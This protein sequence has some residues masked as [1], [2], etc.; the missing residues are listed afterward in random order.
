MPCPS[1][2][3]KIFCASP[4]RLSLSKNLIAFSAFSKT[5]LLNVNHLLVCHKMFWSS[6]KKI[7]NSPNYFGTCRRTRHKTEYNIHNFMI[8]L[9]PHIPHSPQEF[10]MIRH[11]KLEKK[12]SFGLTVSPFSLPLLI[13]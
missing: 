6:P 10:C 12:P 5:N 7:W 3:P 1:T 13:F 4:N 9:V 11:K 8:P 2:G